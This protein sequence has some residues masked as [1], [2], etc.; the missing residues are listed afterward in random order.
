LDEGDELADAPVEKVAK[1]PT[2]KPK[3][4][5]AKSAPDVVAKLDAVKTLDQFNA[6]YDEAMQHLEGMDRNSEEFKRVAQA[7]TR[8]RNRVAG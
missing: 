3:S 2:P 4:V 6:A 7:G 5:S 8:A 1:A